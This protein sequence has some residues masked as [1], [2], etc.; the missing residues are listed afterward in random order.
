MEETRIIK[1]VGNYSYTEAY[2]EDCKVCHNAKYATVL[3]DG[4]CLDC[5]IK[6]SITIEKILETV[7]DV[8]SSDHTLVFNTNGICGIEDVTGQVEIDFGS[9]NMFFNWIIQQ[10]NRT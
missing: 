1:R 3:I 9:L 8:F 6:K 4:V 10:E 5:L 2:P 7:E